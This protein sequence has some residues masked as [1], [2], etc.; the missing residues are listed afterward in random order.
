MPSFRFALLLIALFV[1]FSLFIGHT[2][3]QAQTI[4]TRNCV[5]D[6]DRAPVLFGGARAASLVI[7]ATPLL[8]QPPLS[9]D[10]RPLTIVQLPSRAAVIVTD[11]DTQSRSWFRVIWPCDGQNFTGW[12]RASDVRRNTN[13]VNQ[14]YAPPGCAVPITYVN[15]IDDSWISDVNGNI[16]VVVDLYRNQG[17]NLIARTFYYLAVNGQARR[18][19]DRVIQTS[20]P[21]LI[22]GVVMG[23]NVRRGQA[24]GFQITPPLREETN[25]FGII[26]RVPDGCEFVQ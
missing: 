14:K 18:D 3:A 12:V 20:G 5:Y 10:T 4:D 6:G 22:T 1:G 19:R 9:S 7:N 2:P 15:L 24:I 25:F 11:L 23:I 17:G 13:R 8:S 21:F 26:Y 16:V